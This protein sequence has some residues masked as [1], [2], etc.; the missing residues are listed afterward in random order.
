VLASTAGALLLS[1]PGLAQQLAP[2]WDFIA[3]EKALF[4]DDFSD[5]PKGGAPPH[6]RVRGASAALDTDGRLALRQEVRLAPKAG[7]L[8]GSLT[9][10]LDFSVVK[11]ENTEIDWSFLNTDEDE[12]I[13]LLL[14]FDAES[15]YDARLEV[16]GER[17]GAAEGKYRPGQ[18]N[19]L[20]LWLQGGRMRVYLNGDRAIDVNDLKTP[21]RAGAA[22]SVSPDEGAVVAL[23]RCRIAEAAP[24][25]MAALLSMGRYVSHGITFDLN[26]D[27]VRPES[28]PVLQQVAKALQAQAALRLRIEG[29][30]DS[31]GDAARNLDLSRRRAEAVKNVLVAQF[32]IDAGRL[33]AEG[34]GASRPAAPND[35]PQGRATNRRV[36]FLKI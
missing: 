25:I 29:H 8:P 6:W 16:N 31:T 21:A 23:A 20:N 33:T 22:L 9:V 34:F 1:V 7:A 27:R 4:Y 13:K 17:V 14:R 35:T 12:V 28:A 19:T 11:A 24:D 2:G 18:L 15:G 5:M 36:E 30:T 10:E 26:S 32:Q 3:G